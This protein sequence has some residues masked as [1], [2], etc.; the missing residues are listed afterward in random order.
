[1]GWRGVGRMTFVPNNV[2]P[3]TLKLSIEELLMEFI[4]KANKQ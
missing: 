3:D 4:H 1:M 2:S